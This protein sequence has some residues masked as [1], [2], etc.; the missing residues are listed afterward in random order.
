[1]GAQGKA[2]GEKILTEQLLSKKW[3]NRLLVAGLGLF[4]PLFVLALISRYVHTDEAWIGQQVYSLISRGVIISDLFRDLPPLDEKI[5][6]YHKLLVWAGALSSHVAGWGLYQLRTVSAVA[7]AFTLAMLLFSLRS[8]LSLRTRLAAALILAYTPI[9]WEHMSMFRPEAIVC[10]CGLASFLCVRRCLH[11]H[12]L[13]WALAAGV[14]AGLSALAHAIGLAFAIA[15]VVVLIVERRYRSAILLTLTAAVVFLPYISGYFTD[16]SLFVNQLFHNRVMTPQVAFNWWQPLVNLA[17]EHKRIFRQPGVIGIS[18]AFFLSLFV[19]TRRE[20]RSSRSLL[21]YIATLLLLF[22]MSPLPKITRYT[23]PLTPFFAIVIA[24]VWRQINH[25]EV[26]GYRKTI[27]RIFQ[28]WLIVFFVYG[29]GALGWAALFDRSQEK[30]TNA[31]LAAQMEP[32]SLVIAPF[33]FVYE[34]QPHFTIQSWWGA[35]QS[36]MPGCSASSLEKY[37]KGLDVRYI[38]LD[39]EMVGIWGIDSNL[40]NQQYQQ[41]ELRQSMPEENRWLLEIRK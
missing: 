21:I 37:A 30:Q 13:G 15:G 12:Q 3:R 36:C 23:M 18:V 11:D 24:Q 26:A 5:V 1:M 34:Q 20:M 38:I 25:K 10:C 40:I 32:G 17:E 29:V 35:R 7:G 22:G 27:A 9:F 8:Y 33:D 28:V 41:Y 14:F 2:V 4:L 16:R 6:V 19:M 39:P 31:T